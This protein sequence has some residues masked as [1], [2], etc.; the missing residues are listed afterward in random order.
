M[1]SSYIHNATASPLLLLRAAACRTDLPFG[2]VLTADH[3]DQLLHQHRVSFAAGRNDVYNPVVTLWAFLSQFLSSAKDCA[4]AVTR[5][6]ALR[7]IFALPLCSNA[8]GGYCHAREKLPVP[9]LRDLAYHLGEQL[10]EQAPQQW[11]WKG[12]RCLLGDGTTTS[13]PDTA[14]NQA[15]YPQSKSQKPGVGFPLIRL[16]LLVG[17]ATG[18]L[19][20][21]E[22]SPWHGENNGEPSLLRRLHDRLRRDDILLLDAGFC[23]FWT[24]TLQ[25]QRGVDVVMRLKQAST[26]KAATGK[27]LGPGDYLVTWNK[28]KKRPKWMEQET[29]DSLPDTLTLREVHVKVAKRGFRTE[30]VIVVTTLLDAAAY[31]AADIGALYRQRWHA[32]LD[33]RSI[34]TRLGMDI[35]TSQTPEMLQREIWGHLVSYNLVRRLQAQAAL[36]RG[37]RPRDLSFAAARRQLGTNWEKLAVADDALHE[38]LVQACVQ[39]AAAVTVGNRADRYEPRR[40]KRR[41]KDGK[42]LTKPRAEARADVAAGKENR[43]TKKRRGKAAEGK[44]RSCA[45][46]D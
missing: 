23:S 19:L 45:Q 18:A 13:A 24:A 40:K 20:G 21:A 16:M 5:V 22:M 27:K 43:E 30:K 12:R 3:L 32:E 7:A 17:L 33:I 46:R 37:C 25:S 15:A 31:P 42:L 35:L 29:Y 9:F 39:G 41:P 1:S 8:T 26:S 14:A 44:G 10:E 11:L 2:S 38:R 4:A 6:V 28:P 34:K 36:E